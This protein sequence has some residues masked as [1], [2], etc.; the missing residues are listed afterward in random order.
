MKDDP[1]YRLERNLRKRLAMAIKKNSKAGSAVKDLGCSVAE[2]KKY[3]E[4]KFEPGMTW[5]NYGKYGWHIDHIKPLSKFN[6]TDP[7]EIKQACHYLNMQPMWWQDNLSKGDKYEH[8]EAVDKLAKAAREGKGTTGA[9][10]T[11]VP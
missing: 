5:G 4:S 3:L 6:L 11:K 1:L 7:K 8:D 10:A 9:D 2:F